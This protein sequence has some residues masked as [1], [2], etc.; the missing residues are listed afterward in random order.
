[1]LKVV[2]K[3]QWFYLVCLLIVLSVFSCKKES[4]GNNISKLDLLTNTKWQLTNI[5]HQ[6]QGDNTV[7]D[8]TSIYYK[9]CEM[10]DSYHFTKSNVF[11]RRDSTNTCAVNPSFGLYGSAN[12]SADS[13][14]SKITLNAFP[15]YLYQLEIKTLNQ[16]NLEFTHR[17]KDYFL[18]DVTFTYRFR[19]IP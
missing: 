4:T 16:T 2:Q 6:E 15:S 9:S 12:W 18:K 8:F 14:F 11:F 19:S 7:S 17:V 13:S 3:S 10:D 1:M 5:Y